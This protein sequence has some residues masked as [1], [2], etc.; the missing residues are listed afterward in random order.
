MRYVMGI[1]MESSKCD[2]RSSDSTEDIR[3][4]SL[5]M[6]LLHDFLDILTSKNLIL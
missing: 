2:M 3:K 4:S 6:F 5:E 1:S